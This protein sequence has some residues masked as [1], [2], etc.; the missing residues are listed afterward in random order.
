MRQG[1]PSWRL[2]QGH[3][4]TAVLKWAISRD[5]LPTVMADRAQMRQVFQNILGNAL[6][7]RAEGRVPEIHISASREESQWILRV[8][9]NGIGID[10]RQY[11]RIFM[12][13]QRLHGRD[14][15]SGAGIGLAV[16]KR[17][18]ERHGG[19]IWVESQVGQGSTFYLALPDAESR[20]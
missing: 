18:V 8:K 10:P 12:L 3:F 6:K 11:E 15:Y 1:G 19:R 16:C 9:D 7:F 2:A 4:A 20:S 13:F 14:K 5:A 17:I